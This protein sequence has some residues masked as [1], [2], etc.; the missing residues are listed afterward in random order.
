LPLVS[1]DEI[2]APRT[3]IVRQSATPS[4]ST[5]SLKEDLFP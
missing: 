3:E 2:A 1:A 4:V 5:G